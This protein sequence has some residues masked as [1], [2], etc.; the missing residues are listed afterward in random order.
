LRRRGNV[1]IGTRDP[2]A[3]L[4]V[5]GTGRFDGQLTVE[6][7]AAISVQEGDLTVTGHVL[8][9]EDNKYDLGAEDAQ[10]ANIYG[11]DGSLSGDLTVAGTLTVGT[12]IVVLGGGIT[13]QE[14]GITVRG[15]SGPSGRP[16]RQGACA[17]GGGHVRPW[18]GDAAVAQWVLWEVGGGGEE[19]ALGGGGAGP[20]GVQWGWDC[21]DGRVP[22]AGDRR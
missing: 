19:R 1:G 8:P 10:W 18:V 14:G 12:G 6:G 16:H 15:R 22:G 21:A 11:V 7:G 3:L 4:H 2:A 13:V 9:G 20:A 17:A 5:A